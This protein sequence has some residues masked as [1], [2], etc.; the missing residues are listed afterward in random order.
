MRTK[1]IDCF[2]TSNHWS[3]MTG[4][5]N[6]VGHRSVGKFGTGPGGMNC[7]CCTVVHPSKLKKLFARWSRRK[8]K[9]NINKETE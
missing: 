9:Q 7:P 4:H 6:H 3:S 5:H 8:A 2:D 1:M